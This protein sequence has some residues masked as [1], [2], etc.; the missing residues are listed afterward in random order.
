VLSSVP[1]CHSELLYEDSN[2][3]N[4]RGKEAIFKGKEIAGPASEAT[5]PPLRIIAPTSG[6]LPFHANV[7]ARQIWRRLSND[8][9]TYSML[10]S[11]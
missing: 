2:M 5:E 6:C 4:D 1:F 7:L 11:L 3:V 8:V 10:F 9:C